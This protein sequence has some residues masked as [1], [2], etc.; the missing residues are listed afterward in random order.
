MTGKSERKKVA[1][2]EKQALDM[3]EKELSEAKAKADEYLDM[4]RR[5]QAD[6]ENYHRSFWPTYC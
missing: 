3:K 5:L 4:A 2:E 1:E 6:F